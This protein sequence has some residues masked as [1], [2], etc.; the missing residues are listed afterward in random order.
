VVGRVSTQL[1]D[2]YVALRAMTEQELTALAEADAQDSTLLIN[3]FLQSVKSV[4]SRARVDETFHGSNRKDPGSPKG[5]VNSTIDFTSYLC[6]GRV[7]TVK[8]EK[9]L[10][11]RYIDREIF[12]GRTTGEERVDRRSLD[13]L[14][15]NDRMPVLAEVKIRGDRLPYFALTQVLM[16]AAE[17]QSP[18]QRDRLREHYHDLTWPSGGPFADLYII[19]YDPPKTGKYRKRSFDASKKISERLV[20]DTDFAGYIRRIAYLEAS[21][22]NGVMAFAKGFAF[23][24]GL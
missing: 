7:C 10:S 22:E 4:E 16:L 5:V 17:F 18:G 3:R 12:P 11:F 15:V 24:S 19:A 21:V 1:G 2:Y 23:G 20:A 13:L 14:L 9:A 6:D 8:D